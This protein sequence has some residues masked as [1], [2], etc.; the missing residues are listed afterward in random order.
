MTDAQIDALI[1]KWVLDL[2]G[3]VDAYHQD[4]QYHYQVEWQRNLLITLDRILASENI[5]KPI[6]IRIFERL[7]VAAPDAAAAAKRIME[8]KGFL[9]ES[10]NHWSAWQDPD[11]I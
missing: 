2:P 7:L 3:A 8:F 1:N 11:D 10:R 5:P 6:R 9:S 4:A